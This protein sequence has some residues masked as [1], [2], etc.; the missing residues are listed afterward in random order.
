MYMGKTIVSPY[1][2]FH[3]K[4][5][6][7]IRL[8]K[9]ISIPSTVHGYSLAIEYMREW[10]ISSY[11]KN[12]FKTIH[13]GGKHSYDD[14]R[15]FKQIQQ[16]IKK[17]AVVINPTIN[18][19]YNR[20]NIDLIQGGLDIYTRRSPHYDDRFFSDNSNNL[21]IGIMFKEL[22]MPFNI[23]MR[24]K[25]KAQQLDLLE[26]TRINCRIGSTQ[27]HFVDIDCHVP[28]DIILSL[29]IDVGF[30]TFKDDD[31]YYHIKD[32]ISFLH[33]LNSHSKLPFLYKLRTIN[34]K[35]EFFVRIKHCYV[36]ISCLEGISIDD[37]EQHGSV[38]NNFHIEFNPTLYF[39][40]PSIYS[41][42][43]MAEHRIMN[44]EV[45]D[46]K[47]MYQI[48]SVKPPETNEKGWNQYLTTQWID[49]EKHIKTIQFN[50][51]LG[52]SDLQRVMKH[53]VE[54]G[55]S[56]EMFMDVKLYNG[57]KEIPIYIDWEKFEICVNRDMKEKESDIAIYADL[58]FINN[59]LQNLDNMNSNRIQEGKSKES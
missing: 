22:E 47:A 40:I 42:Y 50:E 34:G 36:R 29:A 12:F 20:E 3:T 43:S 33:Y 28:Y 17:P 52:N 38:E 30:E 18:T 39:T 26:Y 41:Y 57:Q 1:Q 45:G 54:M 9:Y 35:C 10:F 51:L 25:T 19:D 16:Q 11:P 15:R 5:V 55:L 8:N 7:D 44:K 56:P 59:T 24:V 2:I 6:P 32:I 4:S 37:G 46:I 13:I 48:I 31:G 21:H 58:L 49:D 27:T 23:K 14:F 53:V